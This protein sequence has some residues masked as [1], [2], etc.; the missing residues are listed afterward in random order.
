MCFIGITRRDP[1]MEDMSLSMPPDCSD[2]SNA[3]AGI[4]EPSLP[5]GSL[6]FGPR[7]A[8]ALP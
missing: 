3:N 8:M 5:A 6:S 1:K 4:F 7:K 2:A